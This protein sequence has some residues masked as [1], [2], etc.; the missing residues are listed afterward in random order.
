MP[1]VTNCAVSV[2][3]ATPPKYKFGKIWS[4]L[5]RTMGLYDF[6]PLGDRCCTAGD[7]VLFMGG[8]AA[9]ETEAPLEALLTLVETEALCLCSGS[10][11]GCIQ[12]DA[13]NEAGCVAGGGSGCC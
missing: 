5:F 2:A 10:A 4:Q 13:G 12:G 3:A 6:C 7:A 1:C 9:L 8:S 11:A